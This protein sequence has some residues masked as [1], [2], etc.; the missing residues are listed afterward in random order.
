[1]LKRS[2][3]S[4]PLRLLMLFLGFSLCA[5]GLYFMLKADLGMNPW[6]TFHMGLTR[7]S[8][9]SFG[10]ATQ[11]TGLALLIL[12]PLLR[13]IPGLGSI[14]NMIFIGMFID[15]YSYFDLISN[16]SNL[17]DSLIYLGLG[18]LILGFGM[19]LYLFT[20]LGAGPR[21]GLMI[22]LHKRFNISIG[23]VRSIIEVTA[24]SL[25]FLM[26]GKVGIGTIITSLTLGPSLQYIFKIMKFDTKVIVHRSLVDDYN[27]VK[28]ILVK[29][30][31]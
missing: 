27:L 6:G 3:N 7:V 16:P 29:A 9:V 25:G 14:L 10:Q 31:S 30:K 26:G 2:L 17:F 12:S 20:R 8:G 15:L 28:K 22:G 19:Y 18:I 23:I 5:L 4:Y 24:L 11:L 13:I 1:M 21:D